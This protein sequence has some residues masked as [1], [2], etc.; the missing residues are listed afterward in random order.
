MW[1]SLASDA[2]CAA[3]L[4]QALHDYGVIDT[5]ALQAV[6][7][8]PQSAAGFSRSLCTALQA[9]PPVS[10]A[11]QVAVIAVMDGSLAESKQ[12]LQTTDEM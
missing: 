6:L 4:Q 9:A 8:I 10:I 3:A 11:E 12:E 7:E 1:V 2:A 5:D